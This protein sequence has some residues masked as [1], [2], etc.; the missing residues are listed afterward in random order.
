[1]I[2]YPYKLF[3]KLS[4]NYYNPISIK[5]TEKIANVQTNQKNTR[6]LKS[7]LFIEFAPVG[8]FNILLG[9]MDGP[10]KFLA[11]LKI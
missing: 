3:L 4:L 10:Y 1:M 9:L 11:Y 2:I 5:Q 7:F 8:R 6:N